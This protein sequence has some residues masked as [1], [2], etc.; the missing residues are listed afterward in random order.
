MPPII[1]SRERG[2]PVGDVPAVIPLL[3]ALL[4]ALQIGWRMAQAPP[5]AS[6]VALAAP[7]PP[8]RLRLYALGDPVALSRPLMLRLQ[9]FDNQPGISIPYLQLDYQA[10]RAW[11]EAIL[12]LDGRSHYPLFAASRLY[13]GVP[14]A[15]R[16]RLMLDFVYR[17]YLE[18]PLGRWPAMTHAVFV[19]RHRLRDLPLALR[20][21]RALTDHAHE[22]GMPWWASQMQAWVLEDMGEREAAQILLGGLIE[23][24]ASRDPRELAFLKRRLHLM[25]KNPAPPADRSSLP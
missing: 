19:A 24:G 23:H 17:N 9:V 4:L 14:D 5:L 22:P 1:F 15:A 6:P 7:P 13:S 21:A 8:A 10:V 12:A 2:R 18:D 20:Y 3:L 16:Q 11:L 25:D